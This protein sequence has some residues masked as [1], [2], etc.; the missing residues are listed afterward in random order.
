MIS[1]ETPF[2]HLV[3]PMIIVP[4]AVTRTIIFPGSLLEGFANVASMIVLWLGVSLALGRGWCSWGCFYG[5]L[6]EG[7]SRVLKKPV[8]KK[9]DRKW[10]YLPFAVLLVIV[11]TSALTL[12]P[13]YCEWLCPFKAVTSS[14]RS[15]RSPPWCRP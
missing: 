12:S 13:P 1:G 10:I 8:I 3:I 7:F 14:P 9:I 11:L 4:V 2:C 5:G 6:D 15:P